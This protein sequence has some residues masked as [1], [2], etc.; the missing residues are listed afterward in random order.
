MKQKIITKALFIFCIFLW[1][2]GR[3]EAFRSW[4]PSSVE[5]SEI[6]PITIG[7]EKEWFE[8]FIESD[9]AVDISDWKLQKNEG[10]KKR[11]LDYRE[12]LEFGDGILNLAGRSVA[13]T[14][15]GFVLS[16]KSF[17]G[18]GSEVLP[19]DRFILFPENK[20]EK[21]WFFWKKP[22]FSLTDNGATIKILDESGTVLTKATYPKTKSFTKNGQKYAAEIWNL[23]LS[24][25]E[26]FPL[27]FKTTDPK[28]LHTKGKL[29]KESP[30]FPEEVQI[31]FSEIS[32][33]QAAPKKDFLEIYFRSGPEQINLKYA[34]IKHNGTPLYFFEE[35]FWVKPGEFLVLEI[36]ATLSSKKTAPYKIYSSKLKGLSAGSGTYELILF[37]GTSWE[38][39]EDFVCY[40]SGKL[41]Q[42]ETSRVEKN[43]KHW[44]G[45][46]VEIEGLVQN[47]SVARNINFSDTN[48]ATDFFR[49]FNGSAGGVN[50]QKNQSP[51][52]YIT[53]QGTGRTTGIA[54]FTINLTAEESSDPDGAQDLKSFIWKLNGVVFSVDKNPKAFRIETLGD[55]LIE[56]EVEDFSGAKNT[57]T[58]TVSALEKGSTSVN[59]NK[60]TLKVFLEKEFYKPH[61]QK[62]KTATKTGGSDQALVGF[63]DDF[64]IQVDEYILEKLIQTQPATSMENVFILETVVESATKKTNKQQNSLSRRR[65]RK[66]TSKS[67]EQIFD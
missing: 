5:I 16:G 54:P 9:G 55:H 23:K 19:S 15:S 18:T 42:T 53:V 45:A 43:I 27:V 31:L 62:G 38:Q 17:S 2:G 37:S 32:P 21:M 59:F 64:L 12:G 25:K 11:F 57:V 7:E 24:K 22:P 29:N 35:D 20:N 56:L 14:G 66:I 60:K 4:K 63:F 28:Y 51:S 1:T 13:T 67:L 10:T 8:F 49:H 40:Q 36:G 46:C 26:W 30:T 34:E 6:A 3:G 44:Q 52:A 65:F 39:T 50:T 48:R 47:E 58:I 61:T 33:D 41:S